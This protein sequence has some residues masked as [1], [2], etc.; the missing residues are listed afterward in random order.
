VRPPFPNVHT[1]AMARSQRSQRPR[2]SPIEIQIH[3]AIARIESGD[4]RGARVD[5]VALYSKAPP[6]VRQLL[7]C[8]ANLLYFSPIGPRYSL[9]L[10]R[11]ALDVLHNDP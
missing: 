3:C 10:L 4:V 6:S 1:P 5:L 7:R 2:P 9:F 11:R 8:E